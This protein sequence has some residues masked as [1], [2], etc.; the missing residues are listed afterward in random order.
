MDVRSLNKKYWPYQ[1]ELKTSIN[2]QLM[3]EW[4]RTSM[5]NYYTDWYSFNRR[6]NTIYGFRDEQ[7]LLVFK[8]K[9]SNY[10]F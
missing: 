9:W 7:S 10:E 3:D 4:C 1:I 5:G 6:G 2:W 8:L